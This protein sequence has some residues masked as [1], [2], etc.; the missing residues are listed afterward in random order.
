MTIFKSIASSTVLVISI[1]VSV[2]A[3]AAELH[4]DPSGSGTGAVFEGQIEAGDFDRFKD[5]ILKGGRATDIYLASPGGN[6]AEAMKIGML[7]RLLKLSTVVPSK[8]LTNHGRDLVATRH[9]LKNSK[10]YAC[11]SACFFIF[12]GGIYRSS[13]DHG[14][15]ILGIHSPTLSLNDLTKVAPNQA[16]VATDRIRT[17][18]KNYLKVMDVPAKYV[19]EIYSAPKSRVRWIR[20]DEFESDFA[21]FIPELKAFVA[22][23]CGPRPDREPSHQTPK[24]NVQAEQACETRIRDGLAFSAFNDEVKRRNDENSQSM[25]NRVPQGAPN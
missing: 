23:K 9:D 12:V 4:L 22:A 10:D 19:E 21:G 17:I 15:A 2:T 16:T 7:V 11:A 20:N 6:L 5:F 13:A 24:I 25:F 3:V 14:P 1:L 18:I 8:Q